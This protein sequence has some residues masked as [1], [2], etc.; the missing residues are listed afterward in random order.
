MQMEQT[1]DAPFWSIAVDPL[2]SVTANWLV[3][4]SEIRLV[5][6]MCEKPGKHEHCF[7]PPC[8]L[9]TNK[10]SKNGMK[11]GTYCPAAF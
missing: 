2:P 7:C 10:S 9:D 5:F 4:V 6:G 3:T 8:S 11:T 1:R